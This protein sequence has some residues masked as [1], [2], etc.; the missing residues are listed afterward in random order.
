MACSPFPLH[1]F[2]L[3]TCAL[4]SSAHLQVVRQLL[5]AI[6]IDADGKVDIGEWLYYVKSQ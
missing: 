2:V 6:D 5:E 1:R 4:D 3:T